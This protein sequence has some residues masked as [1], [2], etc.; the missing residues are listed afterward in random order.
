[1]IKD[2][3]KMRYLIKWANIEDFVLHNKLNFYLYLSIK[4][5]TILP[6]RKALHLMVNKIKI[7]K[8][9]IK[10]INNYGSHY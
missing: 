7:I 8:F 6:G 5:Y 4:N 10:I 2:L 3:I 9:K 1:M